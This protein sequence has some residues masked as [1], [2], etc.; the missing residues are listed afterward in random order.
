LEAK[1]K[2]ITQVPILIEEF[3]KK[4]IRR[5]IKKKGIIFTVQFT[6]IGVI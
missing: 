1:E 5:V 2:G 6:Y 4:Q 3:R